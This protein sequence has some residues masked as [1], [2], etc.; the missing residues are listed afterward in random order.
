M[1][2]LVYA[3]SCRSGGALSVLSDFYEEA[4]RNENKYPDIKW[5]FLL[6]TQELEPTANIIIERHENSVKSWF[7]RMYFNCHTAKRIAKR[8]SA[9]AVLSLQNMG[10]AGLKLPTVISLHNVLPLYKCSREVLDTFV[11]RMKQRIVN[12][13]ITRS[14]TRADAILVPSEWIRDKLCDKL[15]IQADRIHIAQLSIPSKSELVKGEMRTETADRKCVFFYPAAALPYKNHQVIVNA[16][17]ILASRNIHEYEVLFTF[18]KKQTRTAA[19]MSAEVER[20]NVP[21]TFCG[22]LPRNKVIELYNYGILLFTSKIET[23]AMPL[24]ECKTVGGMMISVNLPYAIAALGDYENKLIFDGD[25]SQALAE[26]MEECIVNGYSKRTILNKAERNKRSDLII[27]VLYQ[28]SS[29]DGE[30]RRCCK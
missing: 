29:P 26:A 22:N 10:I 4:K 1:V 14:L 3:I 12:L 17:K 25:D 2:V 8:H 30:E 21:I 27:S 20:S 16:C 18:E 24:L 15:K 28:V 9:T 11:M 23:D 7:H 6:S 19:I 5:V 13:G